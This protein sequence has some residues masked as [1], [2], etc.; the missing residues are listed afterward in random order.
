MR[1]AAGVAAITATFL[2]IVSQDVNAG[3][4]R[5]GRWRQPPP[6]VPLIVPGGTRLLVVAP[7]PDD[8]TLGA[9]GLIQRVHENGGVVKV[10]YLTDGEGYPEGV[11]VEDHVES[12]SATDYRGY[13]KRRRH[14]ALAALR[15][16]GLDTSAATF[17]RFPDGGLCQLMHR[18]WSEKRAAYRS[19]YTRLDR[20]PKSEMVVPDSEYRGEDLTQEIA[21]IIGEFK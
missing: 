11:Q 2:F 19:P 14:E 17:L 12:P 5:R 15:T 7:H 4:A 9:G 16:L 21:Q 18:Y 6:P 13:G 8:E 1:V 20:P 10:L 3:A